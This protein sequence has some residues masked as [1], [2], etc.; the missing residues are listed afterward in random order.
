MFAVIEL[1]GKQFPVQP[2]TR[3]QCEKLDLDPNAPFTVEKVLMVKNG[4]KVKVGQPYLKG[5]EVRAKVVGHARGKKIIGLKY[6]NK[7]NYRRKYG[8]RQTYTTVQIDSIT[9]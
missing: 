5:V 1:G 8:H 6:K 2:G 9:G 3:L 7:V 4:E